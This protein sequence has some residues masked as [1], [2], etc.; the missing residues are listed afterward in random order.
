MSHFRTAVQCETRSDTSLEFLTS[1]TKVPT[2]ETGVLT[3]TTQTVFPLPGGPR[4]V[5]Y[6]KVMKKKGRLMHTIWNMGPKDKISKSLRAELEERIQINGTVGSQVEKMLP[7]ISDSL[8][9]SLK[10]K[11][12]HRTSDQSQLKQT[13][14]S[15]MFQK[16]IVT[17]TSQAVLNGILRYDLHYSSLKLTQAKFQNRSSRQTYTASPPKFN[18]RSSQRE[19]L[20]PTICAY[21]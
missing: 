6:G 15:N 13:K 16:A 11:E 9:A 21:G 19:V 14:I 20:V 3:P 10:S 7:G 4:G 17:R 18:H 5:I 2:K 1:E 12:T 8:K